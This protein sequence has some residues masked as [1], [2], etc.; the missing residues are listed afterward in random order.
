MVT[1][2]CEAWRL[3][4]E[5]EGHSYGGSQEQA[6][7]ESPVVVHEKVR[8]GRATLSWISRCQDLA[9]ASSTTNAAQN[10]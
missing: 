9:D 4:S 7:P 6:S 5:L 8:E 10:R 2:L 3:R 1:S